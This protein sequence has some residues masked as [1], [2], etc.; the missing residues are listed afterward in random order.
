MVYSLRAPHFVSCQYPTN[1][2]RDLREED[3][4]DLGEGEEVYRLIG[5]DSLS[6]KA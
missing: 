4:E 5:A 6:G 3:W 2:S 1:G